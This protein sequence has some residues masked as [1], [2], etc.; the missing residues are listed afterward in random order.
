MKKNP[1]I[2]TGLYLCVSKTCVFTSLISLQLNLT[3]FVSCWRKHLAGMTHIKKLRKLKL[4]KILA[5]LAR[6][7]N[8]DSP[9]TLIHL[10]RYVPVPV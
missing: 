8:P 2:S 10:L 1:V 3:H 4:Q 7:R 9:Q 5:K 6:Q